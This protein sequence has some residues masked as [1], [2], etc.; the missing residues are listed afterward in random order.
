MFLKNMEQ[1]ILM[2]RIL[3][4]DEIN[5]DDAGE[6][7]E[8]DLAGNFCGGF[9]VDLSVGFFSFFL[10]GVFSAVY[11]YGNEGFGLLDD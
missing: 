5:Q 3:H 6:V 10:G 4:V 9:E 7:A 1:F 2:I 8:A 11:V